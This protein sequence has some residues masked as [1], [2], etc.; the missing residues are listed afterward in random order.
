MTKIFRIKS[1][2]NVKSNIAVITTSQIFYKKIRVNRFQMHIKY[3]IFETDLS[4]KNEIAPSTVMAFV[5]SKI[6]INL[7]K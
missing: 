6:Q 1:L 3:T 4:S 5:P 7:N 2:S